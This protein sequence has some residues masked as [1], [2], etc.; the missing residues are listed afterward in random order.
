MQRRELLKCVSVGVCGGV[1]GCT[2]ESGETPTE[3]AR[4]FERHVS[5]A[6][7]DQASG[8]PP[9]RFDVSVSDVAVTS[10]TTAFLSISTTNTD[11]T[12]WRIQT[13]FYKG[14]S[15]DASE[16]GV[17]LYSLD[18]ADHPPRGYEPSC[19]VD[20]DPSQESISYTGEGLPTH[21]LAPGETATDEYILVN[22]PTDAGCF[23]AGEYH[24]ESSPALYDKNDDWVESVD[25]SWGFD[26]TIA[27][28]VG[29]R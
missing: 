23:P 16:P 4:T 26:I 25:L 5:V 2:S 7:V 28:A 24:F 10:E 12:D 14:E 29:S 11:G 6:A 3:T 9:V 27:A 1:A 20:P 13:P 18:A 21:E 15:E 19:Y 8:D 17:L 22:D